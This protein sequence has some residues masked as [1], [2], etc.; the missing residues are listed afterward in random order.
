MFN[1]CLNIAYILMGNE[2]NIFDA[3]SK[4]FDISLINKAFSK[5]ICDAGC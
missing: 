4:L 2:E 3:K 1:K 5:K